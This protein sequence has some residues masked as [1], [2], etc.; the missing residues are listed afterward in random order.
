MIKAKEFD[1]PDFPALIKVGDPIVIQKRY[2]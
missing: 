1:V 2:G